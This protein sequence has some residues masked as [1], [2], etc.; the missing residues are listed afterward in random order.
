[1]EVLDGAKVHYTRYS[2]TLDEWGDVLRRTATRQVET[3][4][5]N[6]LKDLHPRGKVK[7]ER[8]C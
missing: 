5:Q 4:L 7:Q 8:K 6:H 2:S 3:K 1:L